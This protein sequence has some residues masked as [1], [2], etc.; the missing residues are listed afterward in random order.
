MFTRGTL[1]NLRYL[2][3]L[4]PGLVTIAGNALGGAW[5]WANLVFSW[6]CWQPSSGSSPR[7]ITMSQHPPPFTGSDPDFAC[8]FQV[9][10]LG[11]LFDSIAGG[12]IAGI[13]LIGAALSTGVHSGSSSIVIAHELVHRKHLAWQALGKFLLSQQATS[14]SSLNTCGCTTNGSEHPGTLLLP[15]LARTCTHSSCDRSAVSFRELF[16]WRTSVFGMKVNQ[17]FILI[18]MSGETSRACCLFP[19]CAG[20]SWVGPVWVPGPCRF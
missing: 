5:S 2:W 13:H 14:T 6:D 17:R 15:A 9:V 3:S 20:I 10:A 12:R 4:A 8:R 16:D 18:I 19:S 7:I 11:A 1:R